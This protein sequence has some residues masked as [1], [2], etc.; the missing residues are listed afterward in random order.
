MI[1]LKD[2]LLEAKSP[3]IF[4]PRRIE[5]RIDRYVKKH[6]RYNSDEDL[7]LRKLDIVELPKSLNGITLNVG[8]SFSYNKL[9]SLKNSPRVVNGN[10]WC[11]SNQLTS[12]E[13]AP[14]II[15]GNFSCSHNKI[16]SLDGG[17]EYV[18]DGYDVCHNLLTNLKGMPEHLNGNFSCND[19]K[20]TSLE[21]APKFVGGHFYC[22]R[23]SVKFTEEQVRAVCDV[24]GYILL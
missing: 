20:L 24:K 5:D 12:L 4:I 6:L 13:G 3:D 1:K 7:K 23:N 22:A 8:V 9:T 17:P 18:G 15:K 14:R 10:F 21:G 2:I 16:K 11:T 19:N